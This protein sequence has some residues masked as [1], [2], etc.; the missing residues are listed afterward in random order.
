MPWFLFVLAVG[1]G[2]LIT[3]GIMQFR[4]IKPAAP[5]THIK[6]IETKS[7]FRP[8][9]FCSLKDVLCA[10]EQPAAPDV[11]YQGTA[12]WYEYTLPSGWTSKSAKVCASRDFQRG[13]TVQVTSTETGRTTTCKISDYGPN[14]TVHPDRIIDLSPAVFTELAPLQQGT[15]AVTVTPV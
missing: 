11:K 10:G 5:V 8:S 1:S 14:K 3:A 6:V 13:T 15:V 12:S 7:E 4:G 2:A 9:D